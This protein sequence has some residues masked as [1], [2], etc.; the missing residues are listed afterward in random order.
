MNPQ[1]SRSVFP[2][3]PGIRVGEGLASRPVLA[4]HFPAVSP[5]GPIPP[6][7]R[8]PPAVEEHRGPAPLVVPGD[9]VA[10]PAE[11]PAKPSSPPVAGVP[12]PAVAYPIVC[13]ASQAGY[14]AWWFPAV[15]LSF[16]GVGVALAKHRLARKL[17]MTAAGLVAQ[18]RVVDP[19]RARALS[20]GGDAV[21]LLAARAGVDG[22]PEYPVDP[23]PRGR[24]D[25][26]ALGVRRLDARAS[27]VEPLE[28]HGLLPRGSARETRS[29]S[30]AT[31]SKPDAGSPTDTPRRGACA[32]AGA[33]SAVASATP[34]PAPAEGAGRARSQPATSAHLTTASRD[35]WPVHVW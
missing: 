28:H 35:L 15:G 19:E 21:P 11:W 24:V 8:W 29:P 20:A 33:I 7:T 27:R 34:A 16:F 32:A 2:A 31:S 14:R 30:G 10:S 22:E 4:R 18:D 17:A 3:L 9:R 13:G 12:V 5:H 23:A 6:R 26:R 1:L 25:R